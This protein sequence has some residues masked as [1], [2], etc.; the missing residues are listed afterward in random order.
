M[1]NQLY[2]RQLDVKNIFLNVL[3]KETIFIE[4]PP[5][6]INPNFPN[7]ICHFNHALHSSKQAPR[8][9]LNAYLYVFGLGFF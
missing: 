5:G 8:P 3:L 6:F 1:I 7:H 9:G 2:I 4:Q